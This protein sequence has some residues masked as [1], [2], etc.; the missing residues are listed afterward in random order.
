MP[1][2]VGLNSDCLPQLRGMPLEEVLL[3]D[4]DL[5]ECTPPPDAPGDD[6][7]LLP[8]APK[9]LAVL[10]VRVREGQ[11]GERERRRDGEAV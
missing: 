11:P 4:L 5:G 7:F 3:V 6:A 8:Y 9:L 1:Y 10:E 2:L